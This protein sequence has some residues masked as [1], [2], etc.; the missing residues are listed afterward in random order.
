MAQI[1]PDRYDHITQ[2]IDANQIRL[3]MIQALDVLSMQH[4]LEQPFV[5]GDVRR[6]DLD[7]RESFGGGGPTSDMLFGASARPWEP[8]KKTHDHG[9]HDS[10]LHRN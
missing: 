2:T 7:V 5:Q 10:Y 6:F 3:G 1:L 4:L 9:A 8:Q